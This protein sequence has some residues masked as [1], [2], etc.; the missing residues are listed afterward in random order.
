[1]CSKLEGSVILDSLLEW[2]RAGADLRGARGSSPPSILGSM[3]T[4]QCVAPKLMISSNNNQVT[5]NDRCILFAAGWLAS[6]VTVVGPFGASNQDLVSDCGGRV[7]VTELARP[8]VLKLSPS[9]LGVFPGGITVS[10]SYSAPSYTQAIVMPFSSASFYSR[11]HT[12]N[13]FAASVSVHK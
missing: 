3:N 12:L 10:A 6:P 13:C 9:K 5:W 7:V 2:A 1:M 4:C 11:F 8:S